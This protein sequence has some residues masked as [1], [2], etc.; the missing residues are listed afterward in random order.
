[1]TGDSMRKYVR[2]IHIGSLRCSSSTLDILQLDIDNKNILMLS[3][4]IEGWK[5]AHEATEDSKT[6]LRMYIIV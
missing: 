1:M 5:S 2:L 3:P 6:I 4:C